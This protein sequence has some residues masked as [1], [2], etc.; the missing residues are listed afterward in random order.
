MAS[1]REI[2]RLIAAAKR[3][4][5]SIDV[6]NLN[7]IINNN[8]GQKKSVVKNL[9]R[10]ISRDEKIVRSIGSQNGENKNTPRP[11][12]KF[13]TKVNGKFHRIEM[14]EKGSFNAGII[15]YNENKIICVYR[16]DE[17]GF[18]ACYM[19]NKYSVISDSFY[20][21]KIKNCADPRLV[22]NDK[23][24]LVLIYSSI[25]GLEFSRECIRGCVIMDDRSSG[26]FV[27]NEPFRV[28][29]VDL[30]GRQKNW[31]PFNYEDKIYLIASVE[32]HEIYQLTDSDNCVKVYQTSWHSPWMLKAHHRGNTN[33]IKINEEF[34]LATFHTTMWHKGKCYY[35]NGCY[36][37]SAKPP[38]N[39][40]KCSNRT[41]LPAEAACEKHFRKENEIVCNFPVGMMFEN[42]KVIISY[43]DNDSV[44]KIV[45]YKLEDLINTMI[46]VY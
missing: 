4:M 36:L 17:Y 46:D 20:K 7:T 13:L 14:P 34:Y 37:F 33:A 6:N 41:Y 25:D 43:G 28:S 5:S 27:D 29:P 9:N 40:L 8:Q 30:S 1:K 42:N 31:M 24:Q 26:E 38:F 21:L 35:D 39:V 19:D 12:E 10:G 16:P 2:D 15:R 32:P 45:E 22:W 3:R 23:N 11:V 44:V 18:I